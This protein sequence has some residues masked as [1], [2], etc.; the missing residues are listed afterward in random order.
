VK[1]A[2]LKQLGGSLL[3]TATALSLSKA[4]GASVNL[5]PTDPHFLE[6][7][8]GRTYFDF[9]GG[10]A[11]YWRLVSRLVEQK[12]T[13]QAGKDIQLANGYGA[14]TSGSIT[15]DFVRGKLTPLIGTIADAA[16]GPMY[17]GPFSLPKEA[18]HLA[19]PILADGYIKLYENDPENTAAWAMSLTTLLG[20]SMRPPD[21]PPERNGRDFFGDQAPMFSTPATWRHDPVVKEAESIGYKLTPPPNKITGV[22]LTDAQYDEYA[23][24]AGRLAHQRLSQLIENPS[25]QTAT[26]Q[27]K[28]IVMKATVDSARRQA[29]HVIT[30]QSIHTDNDIMKQA[31]AAKLALHPPG[32]RSYGGGYAAE[33]EATPVQ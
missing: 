27:Q 31:A 1:V 20:V 24:N 8:F 21:P 2:A 16:L 3:A 22:T 14:P 33:P 17:G 19:T 15:F 29:A 28:Q 13:T 25:W 5:N 23:K 30:I 18:M 12:T 6:A 10:N 32:L 26:K 9:T 4:M 11:A 7:Q